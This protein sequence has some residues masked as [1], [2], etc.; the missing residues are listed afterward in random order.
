MPDLNAW[1]DFLQPV[2]PLLGVVVGAVMTGFGQLYKARQER[3]RVIALALSD[4]LEVRHRIVSLNAAIKFFQAKGNVSSVSMPHFRNLFDQ[5][6]P[7][8]DKLDTRF[9]EAVTLLAGMDPV[10]AFDLRSKN[11]L[12]RFMN[13]LRLVATTSGDD[14]AKYEDFESSLIETLT[15]MLNEAVL[16]VAKYHS[17]K[18]NREVKALVA[19]QANFGEDLLPLLK[20]V[21]V[22]EAST[23]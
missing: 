21:G 18:I 12:P 14:L 4:L 8:D 11:L 13:K 20:S 22:G 16:R 23:A 1:K 19:K 9:D 17:Y 15:P 5:I 7:L 10:F 2:F 6:M 3:K